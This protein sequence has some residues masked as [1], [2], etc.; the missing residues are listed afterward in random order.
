M[1]IFLQICASQ[2]EDWYIL[3]SE[4]NNLSNLLMDVPGRGNFFSTVSR[5]HGTETDPAKA[6]IVPLR[7]VP[8]F[9]K[10]N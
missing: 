9:L 2:E 1:N 8:L 10:R 3:I 4:G 7:S 6:Y 5:I